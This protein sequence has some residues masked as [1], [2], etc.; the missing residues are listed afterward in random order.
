MRLDT[1]QR[2]VDY[3]HV[4]GI[5]KDM[6]KLGVNKAR[7]INVYIDVL[8]GGTSASR[9]QIEGLFEHM[10][11]LSKPNGGDDIMIGILPDHIRLRV[12]NGQHRLFAYCKYLVDRWDQIENK[13]P[14]LDPPPAPTD[15]LFAEA[16]IKSAAEILAQ[17]D[18]YWFVNVEYIRE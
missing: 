18:A 12:T 16:L 17:D 5:F 2:P 11:S 3:S 14:P 7:V 13:R 15:C 8:D 10:N 4:D 9:D 6:K 1:T